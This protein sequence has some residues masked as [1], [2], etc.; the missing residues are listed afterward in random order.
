ME[1]DRRFVQNVEHT[2]QIRAE[3]RRQPDSL[4]FAAAQGF[5]GTPKCEITKPNV[6]HEAQ[7]LANLGNDISGDGLLC[8]MKFQFV[9]L[10]SSFACRKI[11]ELINRLALHA[12][13]SR[14]RVQARAM[15]ARTF[16][17]FGR[18]NPF[19]FPLGRQFAFQN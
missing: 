16:V 5:G 17:R 14:D 3:L 7:P 13:M 8:P 2:A 19:R 11:R 4:R 15:T 18:I 9:D 10:A 12:H 6:F 1:T